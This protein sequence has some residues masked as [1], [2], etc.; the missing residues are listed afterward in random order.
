M[1]AQDVSGRDPGSDLLPDL[2]IL[3]GLVFAFGLFLFLAICGPSRSGKSPVPEERPLSAI[4]SQEPVPKASECDLPNSPREAQTPDRS[5]PLSVP[6]AEGRIVSASQLED[7]VT[8][9]FPPAVAEKPPIVVLANNHSESQVMDRQMVPEGDLRSSLRQFAVPVGLNE[10]QVFLLLRNIRLAKPNH[11]HLRG[12]DETVFA[13]LGERAMSGLPFAKGSEC[14]LEQPEAEALDSYSRTLKRQI[15]LTEESE[16]RHPRSSHLS[17]RGQVLA[18]ALKNSR[19]WRAEKAIPAMRQ[20]LQVEDLPVRL[21]LV[22]MLSDSGTPEATEALLNRAV[23]DL[24]PE[25]REAANTALGRL[26]HPGYRQRLLDAFRYPWP[27]IAWHAAETLSAVGDADAVPELVELLDA[28]DPAMPFANESGQ[29]VVKELVGIP[30]ARNCLLCHAASHKKTDLVRRPVPTGSNDSP[31]FGY[32]SSP[33]R[34]D[35]VF[36]RADV[37]YLRQDFSVMHPSNCGNPAERIDYLVR[38]REA[39][40][41]EIAE[42]GKHPLEEVP[43]YPQREAVLYALQKLTGQ[44]PGTR[45]ED[46]R[47]FEF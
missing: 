35:D 3:A 1:S 18:I 47:G 8:A 2:S 4:S 19:K 12:P 39:T 40:P 15:K 32:G 28:S 24:A 9:Q 13:V 7:D 29:M 20:I 27:E 33:I 36:V 46:W 22:A 11:Q 43:P 45:S 38:N 37:T 21:Q 14:E 25:V 34:S 44:N 6:L 41:G 10:N 42:A 16:G 5:K 30:H 17:D 31:G 23:F 26:Y